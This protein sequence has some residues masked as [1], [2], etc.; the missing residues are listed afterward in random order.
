MLAGM[1]R[2]MRETG[3]WTIRQ[4]VSV[5]F[6]GLIIISLGVE[7]LAQGHL[8]YANYWGG[9]VFA[10]YAIGGGLL[11]IAVAALKGRGRA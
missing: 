1:R 4:R 9:A 7:S 5:A 3:F 11:T 2:R 6:V 10:P 8:H